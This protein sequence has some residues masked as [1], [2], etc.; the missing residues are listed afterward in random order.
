M[1]TSYAQAL[2]CEEVFWTSKRSDD[3]I[4]KVKAMHEAQDLLLEFLKAKVPAMKK[5]ETIQQTEIQEWINKIDAVT[6]DFFNDAGLTYKKIPVIRKQVQINQ[7]IIP[8]LKYDVY[9]IE[10][11]NTLTPIARLLSGII[12]QKKLKGLRITYEPMLFILRPGSPAQYDSR[13]KEIYFSVASLVYRMIGISDPV[14]HEL[15][16]ALESAKIYRGEPTLASFE[17]KKGKRKDHEYSDYL[18]L[19]EVEAYLRDLRY[20]K[21]SASKQDKFVDD[22]LRLEA[23]RDKRKESIQTNVKFIR[24]IISSA[25][26]TLKNLKTQDSVASNVTDGIVMMLFMGLD[27]Q[28][29]AGATIMFRPE[30][31]QTAK[32]ALLEN[33]A[34]AERR[35]LE[36]ESELKSFEP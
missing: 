12:Q 11:S 22:V 33:I 20:L 15:T 18:A 7:V 10:G 28:Y 35:L 24:M 34:W 30:Q 16:H 6:E 3:S 8:D 25:R 17:F 21:F 29:Y 9:R 4:P 19:D 13:G 23:Y 14:R 31:N 32:E 1:S 2:R 5:G 27:N 26:E 36:V